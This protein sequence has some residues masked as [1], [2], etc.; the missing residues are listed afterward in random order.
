MFRIG[1]LSVL[2]LYTMIGP[3][4]SLIIIAIAVAYVTSV[5]VTVYKAELTPA[6]LTKDLALIKNAFNTDAIISSTPTK[7]DVISYYTTTTNRDYRLLELFAGPGLHTRLCVDY[8]ILHHTG[9]ARQVMYVL[10]ALAGVHA[11]KTQKS[12]A[13]V[14][15]TKV[16]EIGFGHGFCTLMLA[17]LLPHEEFEF[18]G[19]DLVKR[20]VDIARKEGANYPNVHFHMGDAAT[21]SSYT[22]IFSQHSFDII[23]GVESF[24]HIDTTER[25]RNIISNVALHL[26]FKG[27]LIVIDGFRSENFSQSPPDQQLAMRLAE[28]AFGIREMH[29]MSQWVEVAY[30]AGLELKGM[31]DLTTQA[32]P[33]WTLGWRFAHAILHH[34]PAWVIRRLRATPFIGRS[35]DNLLAVATV[36]HAMR[37]RASAVYGVMVFAKK[38]GERATDL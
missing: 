36:A 3:T 13:P 14:A 31:E 37:D 18:H 30:P 10:N 25:M 22:G 33:F 19:I 23:F 8:P 1:T 4:I 20:H 16:L 6:T 24:C 12:N 32:L 21:A 9:N 27:R 28:R 2:I 15:K 11:L 26:T 29:P 5:F 35:T 34:A 7:Q 38:E 17:G